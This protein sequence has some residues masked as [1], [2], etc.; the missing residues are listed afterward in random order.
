VIR[1]GVRGDALSRARAEVVARALGGPAQLVIIEA[2]PAGLRDALAAG[3]C[4]AVV[5]AYAELPVEEDPRVVLAAVPRREDPRDALCARDGLTLG[6][7]PADAR[8]GTASPLRKMQ[9]DALGLGFEVVLTDELD[10]DK[11]DGFVVAR[12]DLVHLARLGELTEALDPLQVLPAPAQGALAVECRAGDAE[13]LRSTLDDPAARA[14]TTAE[15]ALLA[16]LGGEAAVAG[17]VTAIAGGVTAV[18]DGVTVGALA[19][20]VEDLTD[21]GRVVERLSLRG[22]AATAAGEPLRASAVADIEQAEQVGR[23]VAAELLDLG[24]ASPA[25]RGRSGWEVAE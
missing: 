9:L 8:V 17:G 1:I 12:A 15:R 14:A 2:G 4:D 22:V 5:H 25:Y 20:V 13:L 10:D 21:E 3:Q 7:L 24:A 18:A 19:E 11:L 23:E 16:A 6:E